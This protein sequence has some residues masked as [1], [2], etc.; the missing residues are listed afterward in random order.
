MESCKPIVYLI[1][2]FVLFI[3]GIILFAK[4]DSK[5]PLILLPVISLVVGILL[6][7]IGYK[8]R[9]WSKME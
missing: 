7:I 2:G 9:Q 4:I 1:L 8:E 3:L 5:D 6:L